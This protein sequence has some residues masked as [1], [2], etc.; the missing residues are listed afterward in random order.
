MLKFERHYTDGMK[1]RAFTLLELLTV[2]AVIGI[3]AAILIAS[4]D[5]VK[6][7]ANRTAATSQMRS[8]G[9][10]V[11]MHTQEH[12]N[13]LP[14]PLRPYQMTAYDPSPK[15]GDQLATILAD[16]LDVYEGEGKTLSPAFLTPGCEQAME[17]SGQPPTDVIAFMMNMQMPLGE[18]LIVQPWGSSENGASPQPYS[19][20][21]NTWGFVE[22]DQQLPFVLSNIANRMPAEPVHGD[23]RLA[24]FFDGSVQALDLEYFE[25]YGPRQGG[26]SGGGPGR[27][28]SGGGGGGP[29]MGGPG[30][31]RGKGGPPPR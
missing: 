3:M 7:M 24:W 9:S 25:G 17:G 4:M 20:L 15:G 5:R 11:L 28:P 19:N 27:G 6:R 10:A 18:E 14:G 2:I 23:S 31:G 13:T 12:N 29:G 22:A 8:I 26:D 30:G 16:Y 21:T 1:K